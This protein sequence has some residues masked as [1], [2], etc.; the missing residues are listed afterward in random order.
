MSIEVQNGPMSL[1]FLTKQIWDFLSLMQKPG[2]TNNVSRDF[3]SAAVVEGLA[4]P[5]IRLS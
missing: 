1:K 5:K 2:N 3:F 4:L